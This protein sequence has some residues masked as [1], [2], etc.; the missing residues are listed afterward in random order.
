MGPGVYLML[1][2]LGTPIS[3]GSMGHSGL[4]CL[5]LGFARGPQYLHGCS[6]TGQVHCTPLVNKAACS[7]VS[8]LEKHKEPQI[9]PVQR[10]RHFVCIYY[11][12]V[13]KDMAEPRTI[14]KPGRLHFQPHISASLDIVDGLISWYYIT[15]RK[16]EKP[17]AEEYRVNS[18]V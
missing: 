9:D 7:V 4:V 11:Q 18:P 8:S 13:V 2:I 6:N 15:L 12:Y 10:V 16:K 1:N 17:R 5:Q 3:V 14:S